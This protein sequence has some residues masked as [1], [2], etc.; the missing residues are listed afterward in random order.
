MGQVSVT[1]SGRQYRMSCEDGQESHLLGL[2]QEVDR[3][4]QELRDRVGEVGDTRLA[5]MAAIT[6][7]DELGEATQKIERLERDAAVAADYDLVVNTGTCTLEQAAGIV[8]EAYGARF[9][10]R[11]QAVGAT[12]L[13]E[14]EAG[15]F[16]SE[17][18]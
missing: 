9:G 5:L 8:L 15:A 16:T 12:R 17:A 11:P 14:A 10:R 1:I 18:R 7:L 4:I 3:R 13:S 6:V 2:A